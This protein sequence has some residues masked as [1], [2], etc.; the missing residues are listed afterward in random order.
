[1]AHQVGVEVVGQ[2]DFLHADEVALGDTLGRV[3]VG[4]VGIAQARVA[5]DHAQVGHGRDVR[6]VLVA[7]HHPAVGKLTR[8]GAQV[9]VAGSEGGVKAHDVAIRVGDEEVQVPVL[10]AEHVAQRTGDGGIRRALVDEVACVVRLEVDVAR[11]DVAVLVDECGQTVAVQPLEVHGEERAVGVALLG[12]ARAGD[13][14]DDAVARVEV[15]HLCIGV[16]VD[17]VGAP[18]EVLGHD[19][20]RGEGELLTVRLHRGHVGILH[21]GAAHTRGALRANQVVVVTRIPVELEVDAVVQE[22]QVHADVQL[23]LL[24]VGQG[25]V[26]QA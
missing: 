9:A 11:D 21:D 5:L 20:A 19:V 13:E 18:L 2:R 10:V 23:V 4:V 17:Q 16:R 26:G 14:V 8:H 12:E 22:A 3:V 1:M 6:A 25:G 7:G 24:L 15:G